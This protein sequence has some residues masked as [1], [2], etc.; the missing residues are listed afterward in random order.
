MKHFASQALSCIRVWGLKDNDPRI[1]PNGGSIAIGHPLGMDRSKNSIYCCIGIT[2]KNEKICF[3]YNVC[4]R[5]AGICCNYEKSIN[6]NK[7]KS[8]IISKD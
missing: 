6:I 4:W 3:N 2:F 1:N 7:V 5:G 8:K